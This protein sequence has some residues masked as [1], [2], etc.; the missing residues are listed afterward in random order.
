MKTLNLA[1]EAD[2]IAEFIRF[3]VHSNGFE[4]VILGLSGGI[5]SSLSAALAV[6]ALG[7]ENVLGLIMPHAKSSAHSKEDA[8][9]LANELGIVTMEIG[10]TSITD[11]YFEL[12]EPQANALRQANW[13]ARCRMIILYDQSAKHQALVLGTSNRTEL[14]VGYFT[15]HGDGACAI[16]PIGHL[17]K[18]EVWALARYLHIPQRIIDKT[19]TADLWEGQSDE[20]EMGISYHDLDEALYQIT[21]THPETMNLEAGKIAKVR[22]MILSSEFKRTMPPVLERVYA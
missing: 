11:P 12:I 10:I 21:E 15:Q 3:Y 2:R 1:L 22:K 20:A 18:T 5:D 4:K 14:L 6:R 9:L 13:K 7:R 19:P 16:E 8:L 17:Y